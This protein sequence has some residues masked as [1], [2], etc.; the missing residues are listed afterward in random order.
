MDFMICTI[1][2]YDS[3]LSIYG[4]TRRPDVQREVT[5]IGILHKNLR[6]LVQEIFNSKNPSTKANLVAGLLNNEKNRKVLV[7]LDAEIPT[8]AQVSLNLRCLKEE[9]TDV[10]KIDVDDD[11]DDL[12]GDEVLTMLDDACKKVETQQKPIALVQQ[13]FTSAKVPESFPDV[14]KFKDIGYAYTKD[15]MGESSTFMQSVL[16]GN[17]SLLKIEP[18]MPI[19]TTVMTWP[20]VCFM[21]NAT[22]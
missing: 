2:S 1:S 19:P 20:V 15:R 21:L 8:Q 16:E 22:W 3:L 9:I 4:V 11:V 10:A 18:V 13:L 7:V 5:A 17:F 6:A 12:T 14:S